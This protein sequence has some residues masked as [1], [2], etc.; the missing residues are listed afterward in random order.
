VIFGDQFNLSF[1]LVIFFRQIRFP[2]GTI[3][4]FVNRQKSMIMVL[5][6]KTHST[7]PIRRYV[8]LALTLLKEVVNYGR[9]KNHY[10]NDD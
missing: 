2:Y 3:L 5:D 10:V 7:R 8:F 4:E 1:Q 9:G 6:S